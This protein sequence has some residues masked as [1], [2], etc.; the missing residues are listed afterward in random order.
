ML[1]ISFLIETQLTH[2]IG[3]SRPA[4]GIA[5]AKPRRNW[6]VRYVILYINVFFLF[7]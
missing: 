5:R 6:S 2:F 1:F 3:I 4:N 7:F